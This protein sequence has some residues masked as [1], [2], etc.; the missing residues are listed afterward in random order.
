MGLKPPKMALTGEKLATCTDR[1]AFGGF[2]R[3]M[4]R[5]VFFNPNGIASLS[6]GLAR[7]RESLPWVTKPKRSATP[8]G[9]CLF[10]L[11]MG[12]GSACFG[13]SVIFAVELPVKN[14]KYVCIRRHYR[15]LVNRPPRSLCERKAPYQ[16]PK[17]SHNPLGCQ[18]IQKRRSFFRPRLAH[19]LN[20][21][22][23]VRKTA[24]SQSVTGLFITRNV[25][26]K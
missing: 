10:I 22:C 8:K 19:R 5:V 14:Q 2:T 23:S 24:R 21:L 13:F 4:V 15:L 9:L 25:C 18:I 7:F 12:V 26:C 1:S 17:L 6:P 16:R 20:Q 11:I 3:V